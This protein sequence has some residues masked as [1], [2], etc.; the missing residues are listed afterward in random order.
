MKKCMARAALLVAVAFSC[1]AGTSWGQ[2]VEVSRAWVR[3]AVPGQ[4]ATGAFMEITAATDASL[5]GA[6]SP[7]A[8]SVE[9][10]EMAIEGNV[11]K[12]RAVAKVD[13]PAGKT[14]EFKPGAY[15]IMLLGL[16]KPLA[17]GES[18]PIELTLRAKD[19]KTSK[20]KLN[21]EVRQLGAAP[22]MEGHEHRH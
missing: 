11:M 1:V 20:L 7:V 2:Q 14:V 8:R 16:T 13:L 15:H 19:Q 6:A 21:A 22:M 4:N 9:I 18:V 17:A 10:H 5:V 12:M 3:A